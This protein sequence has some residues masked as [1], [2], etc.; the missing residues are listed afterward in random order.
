MRFLYALTSTRCPPNPFVSDLCN[1]TPLFKALCTLQKG[2]TDLSHFDKGLC[3]GDNI[4][5]S[6]EGAEAVFVGVPCP[7]C[8]EAVAEVGKNSIRWVRCTDVHCDCGYSEPFEWTNP[9][10]QPVLV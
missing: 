10:F 5:G 2:G 1:L 3:A 9:H 4:L 7:Q 6:V 8:G